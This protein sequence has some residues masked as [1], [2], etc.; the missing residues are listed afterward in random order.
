MLNGLCKGYFGEYCWYK[1][2][3]LHK[4]NEAAIIYSDG[5]KEWWI[6]G[7]LHREDG[8]AIEP[9]DGNKLWFINGI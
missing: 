4:E 9:P 8:P 7:K 3:L 2:G 5:R 6:H 1:D